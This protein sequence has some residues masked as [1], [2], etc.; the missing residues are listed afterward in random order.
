MPPSTASPRT[1]SLGTRSCAAGGEMG[2]GS[3]NVFIQQFGGLN[4]PPYPPDIHTQTPD[5]RPD[6]L[7]PPPAHIDTD[8]HTDTDTGTQ[9]QTPTE[10]RRPRHTRTSTHSHPGLLQQTPTAVHTQTHST[11]CKE[12][13]RHTHDPQ[14]HRCSDRHRGISSWRL[15]PQVPN[16]AKRV[17]PPPVP[18]GTP[19]PVATLLPRRRPLPHS[20]SW[21]RLVPPGAQQ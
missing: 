16:K 13:T 5:T 11:V 12:H 2:G 21:E 9:N 7:T 4:W 10:T 20:P 18:F 17:P 19:A 15:G 3:R 1:P 14:R 8:I 6:C